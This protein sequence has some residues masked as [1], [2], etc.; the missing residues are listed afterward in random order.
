MYFIQL[1]S[2]TNVTSSQSQSIFSGQA[3]EG[4]DRWLVLPGPFCY[5]DFRVVVLILLFLICYNN[6]LLFKI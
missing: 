2:L 5:V 3:H 6:V 1:L 4:R